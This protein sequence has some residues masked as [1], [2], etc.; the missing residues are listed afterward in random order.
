M[1]PKN[2]RPVSL[3][4]VL[5]KVL[6]RCIFVQMVK[7]LEENN[8]LHPSHHG[9]RAKHR[10]VTALI[11]MYNTLIDAFER[12][13]VSAVLMLDMSAAFDVVDHKILYSKLELYGFSDCALSW[14]NSYLTNR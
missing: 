14:I 13:E 12:N 9:F 2:Y 1:N 5:S 6:E 8:L 11:Q 3:L 10:T 4:P 7:Y